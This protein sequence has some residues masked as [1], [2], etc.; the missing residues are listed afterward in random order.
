MQG[1]KNVR[2][3]SLFAQVKL[4]ISIRKDGL[5]PPFVGKSRTFS[6]VPAN[7]LPRESQSTELKPRRLDD[8]FLVL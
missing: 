3:G 2:E 5:K 7:C 4:W 8:R 1:K 6:T